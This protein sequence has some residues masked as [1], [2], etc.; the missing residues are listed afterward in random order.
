MRW[1]IKTSS[2]TSTSNGT[3]TKTTKTTRTQYITIGDIVGMAK[4]ATGA[5]KNL[6]TKLPTFIS[7]LKSSGNTTGVSTANMVNNIVQPL[8]AIIQGMDVYKK[9]MGIVETVTPIVQLVARSTGIWCSPGNAADIGQIVL[10]MVE[11]ILISLVTDAIVR[12]KEFIWNYEFKIQEITSTA[13]AVIT[14]NL[15]SA[16]V[17]INAKVS[18]SLSNSVLNATR[19]SSSG[20]ETS[21]SLTLA[22]AQLNELYGKLT[23]ATTSETATG[24]AEAIANLLSNIQKTYGTAYETKY[25]I[26]TDIVRLLRGSSSNNG[27]QY[28]DDGGKSWTDSSETTGSWCCFA[29]INIG[30]ESSPVYRY[31]AGSEPYVE[32]SSLASSTDTDWSKDTNSQYN[33]DYYYIL[34]K[35]IGRYTKLLKDDNDITTMIYKTS[36]GCYNASNLTSSGIYYSD[37][38][39]LTWTASDI[40][41]GYYGNIYEFAK[42]SNGSG[43]IDETV[44]ACN[45]D[46][47]GMIYSTD[48]KSWSSSKM[49]SSDINTG[50]WVK[51]YTSDN[52]TYTAMAYDLEAI[53]KLAK[54]NACT[55]INVSET[56]VSSAAIF[57]LPAA[58]I[59]ISNAQKNLTEI[60]DYIH[61]NY[62]D[63]LPTY[64]DAFWDDKIT[65]IL[66][67]EYTM[68][69]AID[70]VDL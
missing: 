3:T 27:I 63:R 51:I 8:S 6:K 60:I 21:G 50:R 9:A 11:Q 28:S 30:T 67:G 39:G 31:I 33:K 69:D 38:N 37:D 68:Q 58:E 13:S 19:S 17:S 56:A 15:N 32:S 66:A 18:S 12:L 61:E 54:I 14:S 49:D 16:S 43:Y 41:S 4:S 47:T 2:D 70:G 45:Y 53:A 46:Y 35:K 29:K 26:S 55:L 20:V 1:S 59:Y 34:N 5:V 36:K 64:T 65:K 23:N 42:K 62:T 24:T 44:V 40:N 57:S 10:G 52:T 48:G 22:Q 7:S 25:S